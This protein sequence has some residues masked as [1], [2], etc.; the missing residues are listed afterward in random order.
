[1]SSIPSEP[2]PRAV[3]TQRLFVCPTQ[4]TRHQKK[5]PSHRAMRP[6]V[7]DIPFPF[8]FQT[9]QTHRSI[10]PFG[11]SVKP[12]ANAS[13]FPVNSEYLYK[14]SRR[15]RT[16]HVRKNPQNEEGRR[17]A[18]TLSRVQRATER[19]KLTARQMA[20]RARNGRRDLSR[21]VR[22]RTVK[23]HGVVKDV[24]RPCPVY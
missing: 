1:M 2:K 13:F 4:I 20:L 8:R 15:R 22:C 9:L 7:P 17:T 10:P 3:P 21:L 16:F 14:P 19:I 6:P 12:G 11:F 24:L 23:T 5:N 18:G